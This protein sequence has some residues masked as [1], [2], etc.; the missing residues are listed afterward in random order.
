MHSTRRWSDTF[1]V[2]K[3]GVL[4]DVDYMRHWPSISIL[5]YA[6]GIVLSVYQLVI[7]HSLSARAHPSARSPLCL[8]ISNT[9]SPT[10]YLLVVLPAHLSYAPLKSDPKPHMYASELT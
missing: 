2:N 4:V 7:L 10:L 3:R 1:R 6:P 8:Y 9:A 5:L